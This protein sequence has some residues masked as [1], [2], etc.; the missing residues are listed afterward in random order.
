M[1]FTYSPV[2]PERTDAVPSRHSQV[3]GLTG[4]RISGIVT[5]TMKNAFNPKELQNRRNQELLDSCRYMHRETVSSVPPLQLDI[6]GLPRLSEDDITLF[7]ALQID[8]A[9]IAIESV[10][11]QDQRSRPHGWRF[12]HDSAAVVDFIHREPRGT[13]FHHR[14]RPYVHRVLL[15]A[16]GSGFPGPAVRH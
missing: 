11:F 8:A 5:S 12:G 14:K 9:R 10:A 1:I 15:C 13:R 7:E 2:S 16:G 4:C 3:R 6:A